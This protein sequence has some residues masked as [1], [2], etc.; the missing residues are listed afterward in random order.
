M[1]SIVLSFLL[2]AS[3][4]CQGGRQKPTNVT[5]DVFDAANFA[6][7]EINAQSNSEDWFTLL[8]AG[9]ATTQVVTGEIFRMD[10]TM[11]ESACMNSPVNQNATPFDCPV[12]EGASIWK[13]WVEVLYIHWQTP[14]FTLLVMHPET[15]HE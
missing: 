2:V 14:V 15:S 7:N 1:L 6:C 12:P 11:G 8:S 10:L 5:G 4:S 3:V 9:N 13:Y